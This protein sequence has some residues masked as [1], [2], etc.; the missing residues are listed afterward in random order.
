MDWQWDSDLPKKVQT[1]GKGIK[2]IKDEWVW[3]PAK[4]GPG[5][6]YGG[7]QIGELFKDEAYPCGFCSGTGCK[8]KG[9]K[10]PV[11]RGTGTVFIDPPAIKCA[12][13]KGAGTEK[14]RSNVTCSACKGKGVIHVEEPVEMC[15]RC[16]GTGKEVTNKLICITCRGKGVVSVKEEKEAWGFEQEPEDNNF[17]SKEEPVGSASGSE[18]DALKIVK[19][20]GQADSV[21]VSKRMSPPVSSAYAGQLCLALVKKRLLLRSG[22]LYSLTPDGEKAFE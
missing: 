9:S 17:F 20:L 15:P 8:P 22:L 21:T 1:K 11:C 19:E 10:C 3:Q 16:R 5:Q 14:P 6:S 12:Y 13:C 2:K 7:H 18:R 4:I